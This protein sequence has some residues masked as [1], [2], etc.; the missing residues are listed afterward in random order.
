MTFNENGLILK[1]QKEDFI[2]NEIPK[3]FKKMK[4][5]NIDID[6]IVNIYRKE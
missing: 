1:E 4:L 6:D 2:E 3:F 5:Y